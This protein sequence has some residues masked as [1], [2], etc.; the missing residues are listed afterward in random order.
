VLRGQRGRAER[1]CHHRA[2]LGLRAPCQAPWP[3]RAGTMS[4]A[5]GTAHRVGHARGIAHAAP[6]AMAAS[7]HAWAEA[8]CHPSERVEGTTTT[9]GRGRDGPR[10]PGRGYAGADAPC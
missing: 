8:S 3:R 7:G 9:P 1:G 5:R 10:A 4:R 6:G 2:G